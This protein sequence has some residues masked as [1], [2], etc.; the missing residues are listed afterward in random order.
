MA[1]LT[2]ELNELW[3]HVCAVYASDHLLMLTNPDDRTATQISHA[4][5]HNVSKSV[6]VM[7]RA[8]FGQHYQD[9]QLNREIAARAVVALM[10]E[11]AGFTDKPRLDDVFRGVSLP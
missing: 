9:S 6:I 11:R 5:G 7:W 10:W 3:A 4:V 8:Y 1:T 2:E